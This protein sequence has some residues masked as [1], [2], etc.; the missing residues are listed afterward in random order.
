MKLLIA[1]T[2]SDVA[3]HRPI[4]DVVHSAGFPVEAKVYPLA[5]GRQRWATREMA[6][7]GHLMWLR[8]FSARAAMLNAH[9]PKWWMPDYELNGEGTETVRAW[10]DGE[11]VVPEYT[12]KYM[13][14]A[15]AALEF[16]AT[17]AGGSMIQGDPEVLW[18]GLPRLSGLKG[19]DARAKAFAER[20]LDDLKATRVCPSFKIRR[21]IGEGITADGQ[22]ERTR[23]GYL[24]MTEAIGPEFVIPELSCT[25]YGGAIQGVPERDAEA[26][27]AGLMDA[28]C[29]RMVIWAQAETPALGSYIAR[30]MQVFLRGAANAINP[31]ESE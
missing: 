24:S 25:K 4:I 11:L 22:R 27:I 23:V 19:F 7:M 28:G 1:L 31:D 14:S 20:L 6:E 30:H 10:M 5:E 13:A 21:L 2:G 17:E 12:A 29:K 26:A 16:M 15:R 18:Y 3:A 8:R 9:N